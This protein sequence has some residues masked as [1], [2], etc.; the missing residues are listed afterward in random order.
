MYKSTVITQF[1]TLVTDTGLMRKFIH[2]DGEWNETKIDH[3]Y[4]RNFLASEGMSTGHRRPIDVHREQWKT[5]A[6]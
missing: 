5:A 4:Q 6:N 3:W 2:E 1:K